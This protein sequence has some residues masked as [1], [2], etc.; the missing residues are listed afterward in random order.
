MLQCLR[1]GN[2]PDFKLLRW[3]FKFHNV[4]YFNRVDDSVDFQRTQ[5]F[6]I[7]I[8][9]DVNYVSEKLFNAIRAGSVP[10]YYGADLVKMGIP[11]SVCVQL[12]RPA[13]A[14]VLNALKNTDQ[15]SQ[16]IIVEAG[17][18]WIREDPVQQRWN[19]KMGHE[20]IAALISRELENLMPTT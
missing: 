20:R 19:I 5:T 1:A 8:E 9:N 13:P 10:L 17:E 2:M 4:V 18:T 3:P 11:T 6:S 14:D 7:V 15:R 16:E 12:K